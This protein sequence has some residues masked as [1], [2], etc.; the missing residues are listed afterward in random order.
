MAEATTGKK[1][2]YSQLL[3]QVLIAIAIGVVFG[4]LSPENAEKMKPLGDAFI[5]L[6]KMMIAPI[7][8]CTVVTGVA[9]MGNMK[10]VGR[11]GAKALLYFEVITTIALLIGVVVVWI[12]HPGTGM[13]IQPGSVDVS[14]AQAK[15]TG[16]KLD[17]TVDFLMHIIPE[18]FIGAFARGE[19]L[20][21]LL[22]ALLFSGALTAMGDRGR[23]ILEFIDTISH[24][25]F[26]M[27]NIINK[28]AP[29]G[30]FGAMAYTV[31]KFGLGS[32][33]DLIG[34]LLIFYATC[35]V[36]IVCVLG[37]VLWFYCRLSVFKFMRYIKEEL[38]IVLGTSSSETVLPRM[39]GKMTML[40]CK[41]SIVGMVIPTG[42]SFNLDGTSIYLTMAALF[43]ANATNTPLTL[44]HELTILGV[45]LITS[46][47]AAG[48][49]GSGFIVLA[50]TL[51][52]MNVIPHDA[53]LT[54]L[55]L[56][57]AVDRFMSTGRAITNMIGN[58]IATVVI[59]KWEKALDWERADRILDGKEK[60]KEEDLA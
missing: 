48:V 20:Q 56:I 31:G 18:T 50:A 5:N 4:V 12:T 15:L 43:I 54:G 45:L 25:L 37:G 36:F 58:G 16:A 14:T 46:K 35:A 21:V 23:P 8:F 29:I 42:Y 17:S 39:I 44:W 24:A 22:L 52:S 19:I 60:P 9:G 57:F 3:Y 10:Q 47:G 34:L 27:I 51:A 13:N 33:K 40:G 55:A 41:K 1:P 11:V 59:A 6:I 7:I 38:F 30:A 2:F 26:G 49:T 32:L 28:L 53:L